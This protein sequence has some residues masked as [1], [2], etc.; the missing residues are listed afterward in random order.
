[1][2]GWSRLDWDSEF[3]G[4]A[5]GRVDLDGLSPI[6]VAAVEHDA[7]A[8][9]M[10]CL[11][12]SLDPVDRQATVLAQDLGWRFVDAAVMSSLHPKQPPNRTEPDIDI[13][14]GSID[15][16]AELE[17]M[18][19]LLAPWSRFAVDPRFGLEAA[20]RLQRALI[21][22]A[23]SCTSGDHSLVVA[24]REGSII[25]FITRM[26][27]PSPGIDAIGT[28]ALGSGAAR[29]LVEVSRAWAGDQP[30][31]GG[32]IAARNTVAHAFVTS[33][34]YRATWVRYLYHRWLDEEPG[35]A[36]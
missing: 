27:A 15:D 11:Y 19:D 10:V 8:H 3:F 25:A 34:G 26:L 7:R 1:M 32:P 14:A 2:M 30:M 21:E 17:P 28:S 16:L 35:G 36:R 31:L 24:E 33:C 5:I 12:G 18:S 22:R 20:R 9:G 13:R 6:E 4:F 29:Q 23:A